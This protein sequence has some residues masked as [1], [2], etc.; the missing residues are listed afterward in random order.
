[1]GWGKEAATRG[2]A[3]AGPRAPAAAFPAP[4][5]GGR[6]GQ[7]GRGAG[8]EAELRGKEAAG[9]GGGRGASRG[10][11]PGGAAGG[12]ILGRGGA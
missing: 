6:R 9:G 4:G 1:M 10:R 11:R 8:L 3:C 2:A 7:S 12:F 5:C